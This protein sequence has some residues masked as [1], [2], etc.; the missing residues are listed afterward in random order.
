MMRIK[1]FEDFDKGFYKVISRTEF[2]ELANQREIEALTSSDIS[3]ISEV[4]TKLQVMVQVDKIY[5]LDYDSPNKKSRMNSKV[6]REFDAEI[7]RLSQSVGSDIE[8]P[9]LHLSYFDRR[10]AEIDIYNPKDPDY[11]KVFRIIITKQEDEWFLVNKEKHDFFP[12][13]FSQYYECD[14][15]SGLIELLKNIFTK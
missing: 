12:S 11:N 4:L 13:S 8:D 2:T 1:L 9:P 14:Q 5:N 10:I 7:K 6:K 15:L 3:K